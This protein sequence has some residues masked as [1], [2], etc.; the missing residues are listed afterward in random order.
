MKLKSL[1]R[2]LWQQARASVHP[3]QHKKKT[4]RIADVQQLLLWML[5]DGVSPE[6]VF[7]KVCS[8]GTLLNI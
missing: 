6:W 1:E 4:L 2:Q 3:Q 5:E 8:V 7:V